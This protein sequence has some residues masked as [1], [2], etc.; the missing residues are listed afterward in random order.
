MTA[1]PLAFTGFLHFDEL[2]QLRPCNIEI[3]GS[4]A[5]LKIRRSKTDRLQKWDEVLIPRSGSHICP[6]VMLE[7]YMATAS[8]SSSSGL[9][10]FRVITRTAR[11]EMLR[12]SGCISYAKL[13]ELYKMKLQELG[14]N[15]ANY[16][17]HSLQTV[18]AKA[19]ANAGA[20]DHLFKRHRHWKMEM[21]RMATCIWKIQCITYSLSLKN[22][23]FKLVWYV[24]GVGMLSS[25]MEIQK[26]WP[27]FVTL[28]SQ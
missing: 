20:P 14:Y 9:C 27:L 12:A 2:V 13:R 8:I 1:C 22:W 3:D 24:V 18:G 25:G 23:G 15:P 26:H 28:D 16:G 6:V 4:M 21:P 11:G 19:A 17:L 10:L 5:K 7:N